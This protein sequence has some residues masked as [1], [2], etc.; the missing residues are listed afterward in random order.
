MQQTVSFIFIAT[1]SLDFTGDPRKLV[2]VTNL[3]SLAPYSF[4]FEYHP[5]LD[6]FIRG[7]YPAI[8]RR[9]GGSTEVPVCAQNDG[10][11]RQMRSS[12]TN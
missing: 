9:V 10:T 2:M 4:G 12:S 1:R 11:K 5:E 3:I 6:S 7:S 8:L